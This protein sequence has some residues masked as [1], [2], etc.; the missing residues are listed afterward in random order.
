MKDLP[1]LEK[2]SN[3]TTISVHGEMAENLSDM[4]EK[5]YQ[6]KKVCFV[7]PLFSE[8][9]I[10]VDYGTE[11]L[12]KEITEVFGKEIDEQ[13]MNRL[14]NLRYLYFFVA[15]E[16]ASK[17]HIVYF[18]EEKKRFHLTV[19]YIYDENN[20][21]NLNVQIFHLSARCKKYYDNNQ[22]ELTQMGYG[23]VLY[24]LSISD[25]LLSYT[26]RIEYIDEKAVKKL[27]Q[28]HSRNVDTDNQSIIYLKSKKKRYDVSAEEIENYQKRKYRKIKNSWFVRGYYQRYGKE[29]IPRYIPPRINRRNKSSE[30]IPQPST[31]K[32]DD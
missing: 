5:A 9:V 26:N 21:P 28:R 11:K 17:F 14:T 1:S 20:E 29:K 12:N 13:I 15:W 2:L 30:D 18:C 22:Q 3:Y 24:V 10:K 31:Y 16:T 25:Y 23:I 8:Y 27:K 19:N 6:E 32:L 4:F 7:P